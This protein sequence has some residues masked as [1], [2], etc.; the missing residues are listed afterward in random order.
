MS[1]FGYRIPEALIAE[2]NRLREDDLRADLD[3]LG[4]SFRRAGLL[5]RL[6]TDLEALIGQ[7]G[8]LEATVPAWAFAASSGRPGIATAPGDPRGPFDAIAD[9]ATLH[10][11]TGCAPRIA[12]RHPRDRIDDPRSLLDA[13]RHF[14]LSIGAVVADAGDPVGSDPSSLAHADADL[15][16]RAI[17]G[18]LEAAETARVLGG[19]AVV[20]TARRLG[21]VLRGAG[22]RR[23]LD[24]AA[25]A[26]REA[27]GTV[28]AGI[29]IILPCGNVRSL[30]GWGTALI[31]ARTAGEAASCVA[32]GTGEEAALAIA[33]L[34]AAGR[35]GGIY[36]GGRTIRSPDPL[37]LFLP[38]NEFADAE[39]DPEIDLAG[40]R[41]IYVGRPAGAGDPIE[42]L[43][44][45]IDD[46]AKAHA[47]ALLV[48]RAALAALEVKDDPLAA[49]GVLRQALDAD[50]RPIVRAARARKGAAIDPAAVLRSARYRSEKARERGPAPGESR[51]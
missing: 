44:A 15:R 9:A 25:A 47:R 39:T 36:V 23:A 50:V 3:A 1:E 26:L 19:E 8:G 2:E 14:G 11:V 12:I 21:V 45:V 46:V 38:F 18:V 48:D 51:S 42:E 35:L 49:D 34:V 20:V 28:P 22:L 33:C 41:R 40:P 27:C 7:A 30:P 29:R 31:L 24:R 43:A 17:E 37:A 16:A 4:E 5:D 32:A 10:R 13:A 6:G